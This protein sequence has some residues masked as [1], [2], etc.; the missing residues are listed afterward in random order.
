MNRPLWTQA[1][2]SALIGLAIGLAFTYS[3]N[4][5]FGL[6]N[7]PWTLLVVGFASFFSG[8]AGFWNGT[9]ARC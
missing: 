5:I 6:G 2:V 7:S 8:F 1:A 3:L 4:L 9:K